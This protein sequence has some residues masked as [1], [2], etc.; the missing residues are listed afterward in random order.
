MTDIIYMHAI[1][2]TIFINNLNTDG[3]MLKCQYAA[4]RKEWGIAISKQN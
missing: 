4:T 1:A 2:T 3:T